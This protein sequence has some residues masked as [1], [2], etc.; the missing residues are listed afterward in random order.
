GAAGRLAAGSPGGGC[1]YLLCPGQALRHRSRLQGL[2]RGAAAARRLW[3]HPRI[4]AGALCARHAGAP[5]PG[6]HQRDHARHHRA[7][8]VDGRGNRGNPMSDYTN[9]K[10]ERRGH[11]ALVTISNPPANTWT[12]DS[13]RALKQLVADL[14]ADRDIYAL[15]LIGEGEK[16]F[17]AGAD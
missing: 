14:E 5:D 15:V 10:L 12:R 16:F 13:L 7:A 4:P 9:L 3:L 11:T 6:R 1:D 2:Q 8:H 17:S